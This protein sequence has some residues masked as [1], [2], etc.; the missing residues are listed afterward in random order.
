MAWHVLGWF[1]ARPGKMWHVARLVLSPQVKTW[2]MNLFTLIQLACIVLLW[3]V[4]STVA[5]LAFPFVLIMTVPL[6]RFVLPRFFQDRELKAVSCSPTQ[7]F[8]P[9]A[10]VSRLQWRPGGNCLLG[11]GWTQRS[12]PEPRETLSQS[13]AGEGEMG[14]REGRCCCRGEA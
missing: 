9:S 14:E 4:K 1:I 5:S 3:V 2:R 8:L 10:T 6:R 12:P 11:A 13:S 7:G